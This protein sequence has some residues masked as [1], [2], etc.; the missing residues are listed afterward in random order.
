MTKHP[1]LKKKLELLY[2]L[3]IN[4]GIQCNTDLANSVGISK[5]A[6][7]RWVHGSETRPGN[8][9]PINQL[10]NIERLFQIRLHWFARPYADFE[11]Y[12]FDRLDS[13]EGQ[14]ST[15]PGRISVSLLPATNSKVYGRKRELKTLNSIWREGV[16][17]VAQIV[18]FGGVGKSCL[19]NY[20]LSALNTEDYFGAS[21]V[22][23]WSFYWQGASSEIKS[24]GDFFIEHALEWFGD[25][26]PSKGTPLSKATRLADLIRAEKTLLILDG[27]EPLQHTPGPRGGFVESPAV[28]LLIRELAAENNGLCLISSRMEIADLDTFEDE[29]VATLQ[30]GNLPVNAAI[31]L[32]RSL[33][34]HGEQEDFRAAVNKYACHPLSLNLLGGYLSVVSRGAIG[35]FR[36]MDSLYDE[37]SQS[38]HAKRIMEA[39]LEWFAGTPAQYLLYII[40]LLGRATTLQELKSIAAVREIDGLTQ[41]LRSLTH[42]QWS[43]ALKRLDESRLV[44]V[45]NSAGGLVVDSHPFVREHIA[46][47][48]KQSQSFIWLEGNKLLFEFFQRGVSEHPANLHELNNLFRAVIYATRA[49][50]FSEA[51]ELYFFRIKNGYTMLSMGSHFADQACL[52]AFFKEPWSEPVAGLSDEAKN[53]LYSSLAANLISLGEI[54]E[55]MAPS[56]HSMQWFINNEKWVEATGSAAPYISMLIAAGKLDDA[57]SM[58]NDLKPC[59][60]NTNNSVIDAVG[61]SFL[62]YVQYLRGQVDEARGLFEDSERVLTRFDP[63]APVNFPTISAYYCNFLLG[64]G[65]HQ[66]AL[67]RSLKTLAWRKS[68]SWQVAIDTTSLYAS[69]LLVLGLIFLCRGDLVNARIYLDRQVELFRACDEW[70]YLPT[71]LHSRAKYFMKAGDF[72]AA[73]ADLDEALM[74]A[75]RTGAVFGEWESFLNFAAMYRML[76]DAVTCA[77]YLQRASALPDM[78]LYRFRDAEIAELQAY[79]TSHSRA[80]T[81]H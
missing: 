75:S 35:E 39:Y 7:S 71:G 55:A 1:D 33:G 20:W 31:D 38:A 8:H 44:S 63:G 64:T 5:Q 47:A 80:E 51:F 45:S 43:Y 32:L 14:A 9:I 26:N 67:E 37:Q 24:S 19:I 76:E 22:Y 4:P 79:V 69:D 3:R 66:A 48:L 53:H 81:R 15:R 57:V 6:I 70:L 34:V 42:S 30:L 36:K 25:E 78:H 61:L 68:K 10:K 46:G 27:I 56:L 72:Q 50:M 65:A 77:D 17:N 73:K 23:A 74:I 21:R 18:A 2:K 60:S 62:G 11:Q 49:K 59:I 16:A 58:L 13:Q 12:L 40:G 41:G 29:R 52:K 54:R 28:A